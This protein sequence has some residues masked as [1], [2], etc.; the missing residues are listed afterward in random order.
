MSNRS[1]ASV[2][3]RRQ[4]KRTTKGVP[5]LRFGDPAYPANTKNPTSSVSGQAIFIP[6]VNVDSQ[7]PN[8]RSMGTSVASSA[9]KRRLELQLKAEEDLA[10]LTEEAEISRLEAEKSKLDAEAERQRLETEVKKLELENKAAASKLE[11]ER[12]LILKRLSVEQAALDEDEEQGTSLSLDSN[13][14]QEL[15]D[16]DL[17]EQ[18]ATPSNPK[19]QKWLFETPQGSPHIQFQKPVAASTPLNTLNSMADVLAEAITKGIEKSKPQKSDSEVKKFMARQTIAKDLPIFTGAPEEW[20]TFI[21]QYRR[22]TEACGFT[23]DENVARLLKC[24]KG[25]ARETVEAML[26]VPENVN[27]A[28]KDLESRFGRP[29]KVIEVMIDR[30]KKVPEVRLDNMETILDVSNAVKNVVATMKHLNCTGHLTNPHLL[31]ELNSKLP[32]HLQLQWGH[33]VAAKT[34]FQPDLEEFSTWLKT[35]ADAASH[36][37]SQSPKNEKPNQ[38][39]KSQPNTTKKKKKESPV[40]NTVLATTSESKACAF[41]GNSGHVITQC[42]KFQKT[43]LDEKW[44]SVKEKKLC[45]C[46]LKANH[47]VRQCKGKKQCGLENCDRFHNQLLHSPKSIEPPENPPDAAVTASHTTL[48]MAMNSH[49]LLRVIPVTLFGPKGKV[50]TNA[51]LD[52]GSTISL[53]DSDLAKKLGLKGVKSPLNVKWMDASSRQDSDSQIVSLEIT[54]QDA[55]QRFQLK[56]VRTIGNLKLPCQKI[57]FHKLVKK[58]PAITE[59]GIQ[60]FPETEPLILLGQDQSRLIASR[61][62]KEGP[63]NLPLLSRTNLGWCL[64][65]DSGD[66]TSDSQ[67]YFSLNIINEDTVLHELVKQHFSTEGFG[68]Q[69]SRVPFISKEEQRARDLIE[70]H[71]RQIGEK[72][73]T[74]LLWKTDEIE[75][76]ESRTNA[77]KRLKGIENKM[78]RDAEF[79]AQYCKKM[80]DYIAKGY[81]RIVQPAEQGTTNKTWFLP[82]FAVK[83]PNK[84]GKMRVV[85]DAAAKSNGLSLNDCLLKGPDLYNSL[86]GVLFKFRERAVGFGGDIREM[87]L[88]V[89]IKPED[90]HAQRFLWRGIDRKREP[91]VMEMT[92]MIFGAVSSPYVAQEIKNRNAIT[93]GVGLKKAVDA[94]INRHYMDDYLDSCDTMAEA[95]RR[96]A[97]VAYIHSKG[98]FEI[99][100]WFSSDSAVLEDIPEEQRASCAKLIK[101]GE[102]LVEKV[103]GLTWNP[104]QDNFTFHVSF[105]K[106]NPEVLTGAKLPTKRDFLK[107]LMSV[108]DPLGFLAKYTVKGKILLQDVWR[109]GLSW[110]DQLEG[111]LAEKFTVWLNELHVIRQF[112][113]PR[114]Y[115]YAASKTQNI[116]LHIFCDA[117]EMAFCSVAYLRYGYA[118]RVEISLVMAKTRVAPLKPISIPRLE[119]QA[120]VMATRLHKTVMTEHSIEIGDTFFWTDSRTVLCWL[121]SDARKYK[122]F[123]GHRLGEI[124][125]STDVSQ[126]RWIPTKLNVA[127]EAARDNGSDTFSCEDQWIQGPPFL[128]LNEVDWPVEAKIIT[129]VDS[130]ALELKAEF[131]GLVKLLQPP[132]PNVN[133]WSSWLRLIRSTAW[134]LRFVKN[135]QVR[136]NERV[137]TPGI[138]P[139]EIKAAEVM[140]WRKCQSE[141]YS[142]EIVAMKSG[143]SLPK[144][145]RLLGLSPMM[146]DLGIIRMRGRLR[147]Q[148]WIPQQSANPVILDRNHPYVKLMVDHYHTQ[149]G[150]I[151]MEYVVNEL[152]QNFWINDLRAC[153]KSAWFRCQKCKN[154]RAKLQNAEMGQLPPCRFQPYQ[155]PFT[156][157]GLDY[158]GPL[159]VT[160]GRR[161]EKRYGALF[162][163]M[164][165][166][167]VHIELAASLSTDSAIMAILRMCAR[168]GY[169]LH[170]YSDNGTNFH[171]ANNEIRRSIQEL[172]QEK[173][174]G[175][176]TPLGITWHFNPPA[177]PHMGGCWERLVR[178]VKTAL[179]STLKQQAPREEVLLTL[180]NEAESLINSRP[181]TYVPLDFEDQESLT[182]NHFL[183]GTSSQYQPSGEFSDNDLCSRKKWRLAQ[184]LSEHF[185]SR[186]VREYLP[187]LTRRSKWTKRKENLKTG[188]VVIVADPSSP[189]GSWPKGIVTET[190]CGPDGQVRVATVKTTAGIY[191]RPIHKL[192][193][194]DVRKSCEETPVSAP[195]GTMLSSTQHV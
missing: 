30:A 47:S 41:C 86:V 135:C 168:R 22:S 183:L 136:P 99:R 61:E 143:K 187:T 34:P 153:V 139:C 13:L 146:D 109:S 90:C 42:Q 92:S 122:Q 192:C 141:T 137:K 182:P 117:S 112:T 97:E 149:A 10:R 154:A 157:T 165:T 101:D 53:L 118:D 89:T 28:I 152:R 108:F 103:L 96:T 171:G 36:L 63:A 119:L 45:F 78:D 39:S 142:E 121:R 166:R 80:E 106:V 172:D 9:T 37:P 184:R 129:P 51:L 19:V 133:R 85:F 4:S 27:D 87:F 48:S 79:A 173:I 95:R 65:G 176:L 155:R 125:E 110:D 17:D 73:E 2:S 12:K 179:K 62:M 158:F 25:K 21:S 7:S 162:T 178:S 185:W 150:H 191:K 11:R 74:C 98:G 5:P 174:I 15:Q 148:D 58:W 16:E 75:L 50:K 52:E 40:N 194:L 160:V 94:V 145:S 138:S 128:K 72:W 18:N 57:E 111:T 81:A 131:S 35:I 100:N 60:P 151:G 32:G 20:P 64:H 167:A 82:H 91:N 29:D 84:P 120:A 76:P 38:P 177:A 130:E 70:K 195:G 123:V 93:H 144:T 113:I 68:V 169:P 71:T 134:M 54:G 1:E 26:T 161:R 140:W 114:C 3:S 147:G 24:L 69:V 180:L 6:R 49:Y 124:L 105:H 116:Q 170:L 175:R 127:D 190:H 56:G 46:C 126:W 66:G 163:C 33:M 104:E 14:S 189:K 77:M 186:W 156:Y 107:I 164:V 55:S 44:K 43:G 188:D 8:S 115:S 193:V 132:L 181:L 23:N 159:E 67:S 102:S 59:V 88:Q 31:K 83:N